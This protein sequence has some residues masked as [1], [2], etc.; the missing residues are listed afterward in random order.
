MPSMSFMNKLLNQTVAVL[1]AVMAVL[2]SILKLQSMATA[3]HSEKKIVIVCTSC[4][5][6]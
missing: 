1:L 6:F 3:T 2:L 5:L 4:P